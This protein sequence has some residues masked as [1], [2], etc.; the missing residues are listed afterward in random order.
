MDNQ[1]GKK[2]QRP[3]EGRMVFGVAAGFA[4]YFGVDVVLV[5]V[6][7][8]VAAIF[9]VGAGAL[10]YLAGWLLIPEEGESSS[11]ADQFVSKTRS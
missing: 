5:R 11:I 10:A 9:S 8:V 4:D 6:L 1:A 7:F 2:L 3:R